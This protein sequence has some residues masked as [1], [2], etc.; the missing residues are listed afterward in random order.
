[1]TYNNA[2]KYILNSPDYVESVTSGENLRALWNELGHPEKGMKY[3]QLTGSNGKSVTAEML[4]SVYKN[5]DYSVGALT[6]SLRN[7]LRQNIIVNG[8]PLSFDDMAECVGIIY[9]IASKKSK[10]ALDSKSFILTKQE[11]LLT[12]ALLAFKKAKCDLCLI[13]SD[14]KH[15]DP[16]V[17]LPPPFTVAICG[18]IP[19]QNKNEI[20]R[21]R[22]YIS[23]GI[24]EIVS[25]PQDHEA[26]NV[27]SNTCAA[28][29]CRLTIPA[30]SELEVKQL[31]L[32]GSEFSYRGLDYK[33][34]ICGKFQISNAI[35]SIELFNRLSV[36]GYP[37]TYEQIYNGLKNLKLPA[38]FEVLSINPTIIADSTHSDVAISTVCESMSD[39]RNVLGSKIS[40]CLPDSPIVKE[41]VRVLN[42]KKYEIENIIVFG[43][44][45]DTNLDC[46]YC[47]TTKDIIKSILELIKG[48]SVLLISGPSSFTQK[49]RYELLLRLGY[50]PL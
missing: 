11:I 2:Q 34:G 6:T 13:E 24:E 37:V 9:K 31:S 22:S 41:Y 43:E 39:F 8:A 1:M 19:S 48:D 40:L 28:V 15:T 18:V 20:Q 12:A 3:I 16:T 33:L 30:K 21:I 50:L 38:K 27:I 42:E 44:S 47:K 10:Q 5:T 45:Q 23:H 29:N 26:Y 25:S 35:F 17:F 46:I 49:I 32:K 4:V 14:H 7:D 36:K